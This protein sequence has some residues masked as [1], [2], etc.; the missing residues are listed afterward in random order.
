MRDGKVLFVFGHSVAATKLV[1]GPE[2]NLSNQ[3]NHAQKS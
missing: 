2:Q 3:L 1:P